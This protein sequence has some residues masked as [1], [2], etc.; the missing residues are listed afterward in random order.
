[1]VTQNSLRRWLDCAEAYKA[2]TD[3]GISD[4]AL[5]LIPSLRQGSPEGPLY[6][7]L[8]V[9]AGTK[10]P[11][12]F[13]ERSLERHAG[14]CRAELYRIRG[15]HL[16]KAEPETARNLFLQGISLARVQ[17]AL[18]WELRSAISLFET[19]VASFGTE[20]RI[21]LA[22]VLDRSRQQLKTADGRRAT[23]FLE[24]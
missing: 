8:V 12:G 17:S 11:I 10:L 18:T 15:M 19:P 2:V 4:E 16:R 5:A 22:G 24:C 9:L 1:M 7:N 13:V 14:W 23:Q 3:T 20:D 21:R 6:E